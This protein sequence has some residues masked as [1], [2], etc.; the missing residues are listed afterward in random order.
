[1]SKFR[2]TKYKTPSGVFKRAVV[3]EIDDTP[4]TDKKHISRKRVQDEVFDLHDSV[5]D[6][7]KWASL[8]TGFVIRIYNALPEE[9]KN[10]IDPS[11]RQLIEALSAQFLETP[12]R[13]DVQIDKEG[14]G[15]IDR[16]LSRQKEVADIIGK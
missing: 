10:N 7:A 8:L 11:D 13:L 12:T 6:N 9:I 15:V 4:K 3:E 14:Y 5:A 1:M 16:M 2:E